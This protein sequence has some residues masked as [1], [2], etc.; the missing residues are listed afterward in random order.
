MDSKVKDKV[1][2]IL[3]QVGK[4]ESCLINESEAQNRKNS[5]SCKKLLL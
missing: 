5:K 1:L 2:P 4:I 3:S